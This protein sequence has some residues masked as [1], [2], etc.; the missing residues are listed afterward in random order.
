M[1]GVWTT[2][3][4]SDDEI[5]AAADSAFEL[6]QQPGVFEG[7]ILINGLGERVGSSVRYWRWAKRIASEL[8]ASHVVPG[9]DYAL[10]EVVHCG[11]RFQEGVGAA[12]ETCTS[13]YL[14]GV[15]G[16]S[17]ARVVVAVG[18]MANRALRERYGIDVAGKAWGPVAISGRQRWVLRLTHPS[19]PVAWGLDSNLTAIDL[20]AVRRFIASER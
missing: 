13:L 20:A 7:E 2:S 14:D 9:R 3:A 6:G 17:P 4:S 15:L 11:S 12:L 10:A 18:V 5:L 8:L 16:S 19:A 1:P